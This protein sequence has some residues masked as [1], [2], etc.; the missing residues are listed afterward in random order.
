MTAHEAGDAFSCFGSTC[1]VFVIADEPAAAARAV[2]GARRRLLSWHQRF[3]RFQPTSEL[4]LLNGDTRR[5][6]PVGPLMARLAAAALIAAERTGGLV[7]AT[8]IDEIEQA[9]YTHDLRAGVSL[10]RA[11]SLAPPRRPA[12]PS[13]AARWRSLTVDREANVVSRPPGV[14]LD[15]GGIAKGLFADV[16]AEW[17]GDHASFAVECA[18]DVRLGGRAATPRKVLVE[19]PFDGE[20][21]H[22]FDLAE[23]GIATTG[24]GKRSWLDANGRPA[25][26]LLDPSTG[27]PAYT[28]VVQATALAPTAVE[29]E[30][31]AKAAVLSG[32]GG[33]LEWIPD[34]GVIVYDDQSTEVVEVPALRAYG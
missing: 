33:A 23:A 18:G 30:I 29:A 13:G 12:R 1:S 20:V 32:P 22:A 6:V 15:S 34:G 9:G 27:Q 3:T 14:K 5:E 4:M 8:L 11:L 19:S 2:A 28:G 31:R 21:L 10:A 24:I 17:L 7:D 16:L 25:H 26:H